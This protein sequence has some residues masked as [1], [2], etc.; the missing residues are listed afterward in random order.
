MSGAEAAGATAK[1]VREGAG[2]FRTGDCGVFSVR[3]DDRVRWL[4]GMVSGDIGALD[5]QGPGAG[6][7]AL[8]LTNRG[9]IVADLHI[10]HTGDAFRVECQ[11]SAVPA[12]LETLE[13]FIIA[14]DVTLEDETEETEC[15]GLEGPQA[16]AIL[17]AA[18]G[19][20]AASL[21]ERPRESWAEA[22]IAGAPVRLGA[23][24]WTGEHAFQI[25]V[26]RAAADA[27]AAALG[28]A[29][30]AQ[31][32]VEG[33]AALL[34]ELRIEAGIPVLGAELDDNVLPP[35]ARLE[36]AIAVNKGC[37]VGQEIVARLR[38]RGQVNHLLVGIAWDEA[39]LANASASAEAASA[40][41]GTEL[42]A[43]DRRTG[44]ITSAAVSAAAG[45]VALAYVRR[46]HAEPGT[47]LVFDSAEGS[48]ARGPARVVALP[49]APAAQSPH[50]SRS[51]DS[52]PA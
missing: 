17:A 40:L 24:G 14:D 8:L 32:L 45:G 48:S 25:F 37:Y 27:V 21:A 39:S 38:A 31:P 20:P 49:F 42:F 35:E 41:V 51:A 13:R 46:E 11:A 18:S 30:A 33:D 4:D 36:S 28:A 44:R 23:F 9:K 10:G 26:P 34:L 43:G 19:M 15:L 3:G 22:Q 52:A 50:S 6:C 5:A 2:L 7:Y 16:P 1:A 29:S 12:V 47:E